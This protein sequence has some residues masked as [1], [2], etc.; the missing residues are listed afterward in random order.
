M[1]TIA[2][3]LAIAFLLALSVRAEAETITIAAAS[4]LKF[5]MDEIASDFRKANP[6]HTVEVIYGSSG[7]FHAQ[8]QQGAPYDLFFS[9]DIGYPRELS[10]GGFASSGVRPYALGRDR[11][12]TRLNSSHGKLSRMPSS[13]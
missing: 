1:P 13:A 6:G 3:T 4:D 11:K 7:K 12:S 10:R 5:A 8:I 9:A 2:K